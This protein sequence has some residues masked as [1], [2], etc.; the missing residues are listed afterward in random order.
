M[1]L[2][3]SENTGKCSIEVIERDCGEYL[4]IGVVAFG[5]CCSNLDI[6]TS[7]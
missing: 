4:I 7:F 1:Y 5:L 3:I 2:S 6:N